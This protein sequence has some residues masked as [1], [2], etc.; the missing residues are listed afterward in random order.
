MPIDEG[1]HH[2]V[3]RAGHTRDRASLDDRL[4]GQRER[5]WDGYFETGTVNVART[6]SQPAG[7]RPPLRMKPG[8]DSCSPNTISPSKPSFRMA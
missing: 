7:M 5:N 1:L 4:T 8:G 3:G 2:V 6:M